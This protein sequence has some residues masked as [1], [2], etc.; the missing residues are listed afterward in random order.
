MKLDIERARRRIS[1][2]VQGRDDRLLVLLR[3]EP[4]RL[5]ESGFQKWIR[6]LAHDYEDDVEV[7]ACIGPKTQ[8]PDGKRRENCFDLPLERLVEMLAVNGVAAAF[9]T[10]DLRVNGWLGSHAAWAI[11]WNFESALL[12]GSRL[13][14]TIDSMHEWATRR[15][16]NKAPSTPSPG[17][18]IPPGCARLLSAVPEQ[19]EGGARSQALVVD[20]TCRP[21]LTQHGYALARYFGE[22][23]RDDI[24]HVIGALLDATAGSTHPTG[25]DVDAASVDTWSTHNVDFVEATMDLL[26]NAVRERRMTLTTRPLGSL[27]HRL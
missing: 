18:V 4:L 19:R 7:L 16:S 8:R 10:G 25:D 9:S 20:L 26:A 14:D 24:T 5:R 11:H 13:T 2:I 6:Q 15:D 27:W 21:G 12:E 3:S 17:I 23:I 22:A 1:A